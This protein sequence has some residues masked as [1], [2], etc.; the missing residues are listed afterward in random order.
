M[1]FNHLILLLKGA[2]LTLR[3]CLLG[4]A[5]GSVAGFFIGL[6][7]AS[8]NKFLNLLSLCYVETFRNSPLLIQLF[9]LYY[10]LPILFN[11]HIPAQTTATIAITLYTAGYM[12]EVFKSAISAIEKGQ[13]EASYSLGLSYTHS[14]R[15]VIL[16]QAFRIAIPPLVGVFVMVLKDSSLVSIIGFVELTRMAAMVRSLTFT[17]F[18][19]FG[20]TAVLYFIM[21]YGFSKLGSFLEKKLEIAKVR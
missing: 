13:W 10:G 11:T 17:T 6:M 4:M 21:C 9:L 16:P 15:C 3:I 2:L 7:R 20:V 14:L 12:A 19:V 5:L 1:N 18:D 8:K